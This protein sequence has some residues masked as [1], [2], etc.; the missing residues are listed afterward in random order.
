MLKNNLKLAWRNLLKHKSYSFINIFGLT[1]GVAAALFILQYV[2]HEQGY[3][4]FHSK[5]DRIY[6]LPISFYH[7]GELDYNDAMNYA[8][9]GPALKNDVPE[10]EEFVRITPEYDR[11][12]MRRGN[13]YFEEEKIYYADSTLL[14]V[15]DFELLEGD[16]KTCL[17]KP[18]TIL[19]TKSVAERY[20]GPQGSWRESP[21]GKT[22]QINNREDLIV[23]GILADVPEN[24]HIKFNALL[25]F[26][27]F[28]AYGNDPSQ[29]W[30][31]NDFYTY[32]LLKEGTDVQTFTDKMPEFL[33]THSTNNEA[34]I[35]DRFIVQPLTDIHLKSNMS[36]EPE[37]NGDYQTVYFLSL[38][39]LAILFIAW[40]NYINLA[41]ARAEERAKEVGVRKVIGAGKKSLVFQFLT[42]SFII[43]SLAILLAIVL[44]QL[45]Q[46]FIPN[47]IGKTLLSL[48]SQINLIAWLLPILLIAGTVLSGLYPSFF[49]SAFSPAKILKGGTHKQSRGVWLRKSLVVFQYAV[50]V[51]LIAGT[52]IVYK[53]LNF[54]QQKD[55]GFTV[56][57]KLVV[58][59]PSTI[60][61]DSL[62]NMQYNSFK[63]ELLQ[64]PEIESVASSESVPGRNYFLDVNVH[65]GIHLVGADEKEAADY[66]VFKIDEDFVPNYKMK[67]IAGRNFSKEM[68]TDEEAVLINQTAM[69]RLGIQN[70]EEAIG[71]KIQYWDKQNKI[72]GVVNDYHHKSVRH[73][74]DPMILRDSKSEIK[75]F[76]INFSAGNNMEHLI[77]NIQKTWDRVYPNTPFNHFFLDDQFNQQYAADQQLG[78]LV[79]LFSILTILIA[80]LGLFGLASYTVAVRTKEIGI[81][82]VLGAPVG[83]IVF[84]L[85]KGYF[86]LLFLAIIIGVPLT[87]YVFSKWLDNFAFSI[88]LEYWLFVL[89]CILVVLI[90]LSAV[91]TQ[92]LRAAMGNPVEALRQE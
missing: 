17:T 26:S 2:Q 20:F 61:G 44:V 27:T 4:R 77:G 29:H 86:Q 59:A 60:K 85:T 50:S 51:M 39:A 35:Y 89:P 73:Q 57:Q 13:Q 45:C 64:F 63:N 46:P 1:L 38:M 12:V 70:P 30:G 71:K 21:I 56:D 62:F 54:M 53:Q 68:R 3:D 6:R 15:F 90:A 76:S 28:L 41:T 67:I 31:W 58:N 55:L 25:S 84:M 69:R 80:C 87:F 81:R 33:K 72:V 65:G 8:P 82:K 24:S 14:E 5:A 9:T 11:V 78:K 43:N 83:N 74:F 47:L 18:H 16:K 48:F 23:T 19:L 79:G 32:I 22:V 36:Y 10:V 91:G 34:G 37:V 92:S 49:L 75:Y 42:E 52:F 40:V 88:S 66:N 7:Q